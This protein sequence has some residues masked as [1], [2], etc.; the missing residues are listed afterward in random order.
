MYGP[1]LR[2][3]AGD[4]ER[5]RLRHVDDVAVLQPTSRPR[6]RAADPSRL[7]RTTSESFSCRA[8]SVA[9]ARRS[10]R[11][12]G[13]R[14]GGAGGG[15]ASSSVSV[16]GHGDL[17]G[18]THLAA[19]EHALALEP[20]IS[21]RTCGFL[22]KPAA[23]SARDAVLQF[24]G[25]SPLAEHGRCRERDE[26]VAVDAVAV[27]QRSAS[28]KTVIFSRSCGRS[29]SGPAR[30]PRGSG[31]GGGPGGG[32]RLLGEQRGEQDVMSRFIALVHQFHERYMP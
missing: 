22:M 24:A 32:W 29:C 5:L 20:P 12:C 10:A 15:S 26:A 8:S 19:D 21:A 31:R 4:E 18:L 14:G 2:T 30:R 7:T 27:G 16:P 1:L 6:A 17:A 9:V 28:S 25:V 11:C 13:R 23:S 3:C